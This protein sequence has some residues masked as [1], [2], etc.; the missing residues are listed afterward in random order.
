LG[1]Y[2]EDKLEKG[3]TKKISEFLF[4]RQD[5]KED[6]GK[7]LDMRT[8]VFGKDFMNALT[9]YRILEEQYDCKAA[10]E[11]ANMLERLAISYDRM[12]RLEGVSI[13]KGNQP[14][15]ETLIKGVAADLKKIA[16]EGEE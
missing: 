15:Q 12:S 5:G 4:G 14:K 13:L 6:D 9:Y 2:Q 7:F 11:I 1:H 3:V 8:H 16:D 10:G